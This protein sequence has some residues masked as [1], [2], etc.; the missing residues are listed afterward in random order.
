MKEKILWIKLI[1]II[2][3]IALLLIKANENRIL[4]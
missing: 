4:F 3:A 2:G 1:A